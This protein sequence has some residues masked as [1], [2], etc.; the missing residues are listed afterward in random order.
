M[1]SSGHHVEMSSERKVDVTPLTPWVGAKSC[2]SQKEASS[3]VQP[4]QLNVCS[5]ESRAGSVMGDPS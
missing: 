5:P 4:H 3:R 2:I 1:T